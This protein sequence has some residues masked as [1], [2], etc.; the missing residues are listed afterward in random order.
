MNGTWSAFPTN[1]IYTVDKLVPD[2]ISPRMSDFLEAIGLGFV[3]TASTAKTSFVIPPD[4]DDS[5]VNLALLGF[6][7][8]T[9]SSH[10]PFWNSL[11]YKKNEFYARALKYAYRPF[12]PNITLNQ[13]A[14]QIDPRT[15]YIIRGFLD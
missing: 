5:S 9:N 14:D 15:Y 10:Y 12:G 3:V 1:L 11:N 7:K 2:N 6:L 4:N 13:W 8:E